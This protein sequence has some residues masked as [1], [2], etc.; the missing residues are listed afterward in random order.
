MSKKLEHLARRGI[1]GGGRWQ[2]LDA[3]GIDEDRRRQRFASRDHNVE[4]S[5]APIVLELL[6]CV[7]AV[8]QHVDPSA[9][10]SRR[11]WRNV[12]VSRVGQRIGESLVPSVWAYRVPLQAPLAVVM[13]EQYLH[14]AVTGHADA[15]RIR[16]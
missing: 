16:A 11:L 5:L 2:N 12:G 4:E 14:R 13:R 7:G 6:L 1:G 9:A 10:E 15:P 8:S 3:P